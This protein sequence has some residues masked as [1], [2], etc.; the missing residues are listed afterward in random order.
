MTHKA[1][2]LIARME[3]YAKFPYLIEVTHP[4]FD[5]PLYFANS[6]KDIDYNGETYKAAYFTIDPPD[7]DNSKIGDGQVTISA[8]DQF[9]IEK[10]RSTQ[11]AAKIKF[12]AVIVYDDG[13]I[14]GI[15]SIEEMA[16]T[17]RAV[18]WNENTITWNL[19]FDDT[20][21]IMVPCDKATA[22]KCPGAA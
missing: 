9:W 19:V 21:S 6:D 11:I 3:T 17:L 4:A 18:N 5:T 13:I 14:S 16:F 12:L 1:E 22:L 2:Q 15:E 10:I 7:K 20:M 8:V